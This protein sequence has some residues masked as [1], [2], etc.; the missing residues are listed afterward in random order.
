[1]T[2]RGRGIAALILLLS[3]VG[4]VICT[5]LQPPIVSALGFQPGQSQSSRF[6][7]VWCTQGDPARRCSIIDNG[8]FLN[9]TNENGD[10]SVGNYQGSTGIVAPGWQFVTGTL[11][12]DGNQINWS[13]GTYWARCYSG[14][15]DGGHGKFYLSGTW[16]SQGN[17]SQ[18]CSI[19][20]RGRSL[21]LSNEQGDD[22]T[23]ELDGKRRLTTNW[24]G[25]TIGG[26]I[27][28]DGNRIDWDNGTYWIRYRL[29]SS[30]P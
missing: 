7:G 30:Q 8:A 6:T 21:S 29:Y 4:L 15:G 18:R 10:T 16:Y 23:G 25:N 27:S 9:L 28:P 24:N 20:Q 19:R 5:Q 14:G 22:A 3:G 17:R 12:Q 26:K 11:S 1:V 2:Q 13:N